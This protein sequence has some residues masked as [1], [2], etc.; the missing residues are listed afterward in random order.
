MKN[1]EIQ[2]LRKEKE[3]VEKILLLKDEEMASVTFKN[4]E[5]TGKL[6][7]ELMQALKTSWSQSEYISN[8]QMWFKPQSKRPEI[9]W[10]PLD[11]DVKAVTDGIIKQGVFLV[12]DWVSAADVLKAQKKKKKSE[13]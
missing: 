6:A 5:L 3:R 13:P 1:L 2:R 9:T 12:N 8:M 10:H 11:E 7:E 4:K